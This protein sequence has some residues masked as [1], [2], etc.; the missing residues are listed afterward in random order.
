MQGGYRRPDETQLT[1]DTEFRVED[2]IDFN[3][4]VGEAVLAQRAAVSSLEALHFSR[5]RIHL[6]YRNLPV[7]KGPPNS[8]CMYTTNHVLTVYKNNILSV[9]D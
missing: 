1:A 8:H 2:R 3:G 6:P 9:S 5:V 7:R 4:Q